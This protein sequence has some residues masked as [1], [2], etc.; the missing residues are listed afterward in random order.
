MR[1]RALE[2]YHREQR[3]Y[4][5]E[6]YRNA[7]YENDVCS[8]Q[9]AREQLAYIREL[10]EYEEEKRR[11]EYLRSPEYKEK[12]RRQ[13]EAREKLIRDIRRYVFII[14]ISLKKTVSYIT[15]KVKEM[16]NDHNNHRV[17]YKRK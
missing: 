12:V 5:N 7:R 2:Q 6:A 10:R 8:A 3:S 13:R 4:R 16:C 14:C 11:Q 9:L 1:D 17:S 15:R